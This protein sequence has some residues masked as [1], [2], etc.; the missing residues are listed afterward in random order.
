M[1]KLSLKATRFVVDALE[2]YRRHLDQELQREGIQDDE[3]SDL[4]NDRRYLEAIKHDLEEY[5]DGLAHHRG[6]VTAGG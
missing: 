5:R 4:E 2:H 1:V 3:A 6:G